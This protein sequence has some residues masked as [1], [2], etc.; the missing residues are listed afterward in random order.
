MYD[1]RE[2]MKIKLIQV[3]NGYTMITIVIGVLIKYSLSFFLDIPKVIIYLG[4]LLIVF[5]LFRVLPS[6]NSNYF[7]AFYLE[8]RFQ[9]DHLID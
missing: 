2:Y 9:R 8:F 6:Q 1:R 7:L 4:T 5:S 3:I